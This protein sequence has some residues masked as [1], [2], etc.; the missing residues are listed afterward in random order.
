MIKKGRKSKSID[1]II[2]K[3]I[4]IFGFTPEE[5]TQRNKVWMLENGYITKIEKKS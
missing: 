5:I 1:K 2:E 4:E 3:S